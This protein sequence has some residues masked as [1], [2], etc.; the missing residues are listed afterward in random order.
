MV[1]RPALQ[2]IATAKTV[3]AIDAGDD[4]ACATTSSG[5]L[6]WGHND[7]GALGNGLFDPASSSTPVDVMV[8][9]AIP[10]IAGWHAC[11]LENN[12]VFCWGRNAEGELGDNTTTRQ[13]MAQRV[14]GL[15]GVT[16]IAT[17]GGPTDF[18]AS[19]AIAGGRLFC[20]GAGT[21]GRLGTGGTANE[22]V[23]R[24][25]Q[26]PGKPVEVALGYAHTC[27]LLLNGEL[28][29]WGRG[30]DGQLGSGM[31]ASS[32]TPVRVQSPGS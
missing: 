32:P 11:A 30:N 22:L 8:V 7:D 13:A 20:W 9:T 2:P 31:F 24:E 26:L 4:H 29:C 27:A 16:Y 6:C 14:P 1:T 10:R 3:I 15:D 12:S 19:C 5:P 25:I 18:D 17:G 28:W 23:P 21:A